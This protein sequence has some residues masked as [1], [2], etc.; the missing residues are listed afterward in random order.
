MARDPQ[1]RRLYDRAAGELG[2]R[3][4]ELTASDTYADA[5]ATAAVLRRRA[6]RELRDN[7]RRWLHLMNLPAGSDMSVLRRQVGDL[8]REV[9]ELNKRLEDA[10]ASPPSPPRDTQE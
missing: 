8:E 2:P 9:R 4:S 3:L 1:W 10:G 7:S 5:V 6:L